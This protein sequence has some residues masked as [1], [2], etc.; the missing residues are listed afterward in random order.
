MAKYVLLDNVNH[1]DLK[2]ITDRSAKYG[3]SIPT[4]VTF[5]FEFRDILAHY[6]I[7][8]SKDP[9]SGQFHS[10]ALLGFAENE[11]LFL[12]EDGW[13]SSYVPLMIERQ[14]FSIGFQQQGQSV[15][16]EMQRVVHVDMDSPRTNMEEGQNLFLQHGGTTTYLQRI[17][18]VLEAVYQGQ[19]GSMKFIDALIKH[20]LLES[21]TLDVKL[22]DGSDNKLKG[23]YT[24]NEDKLNALPAETKVKLMDDGYLESIYMVLAS[25]SNFRALIERKN[26]KCSIPSH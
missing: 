11:N 25:F 23:F 18:S 26:Q 9:K 5:P 8:F 19:Q 1:K 20:Q 6:P 16:A 15:S 22:N 12:S 10:I 7:C 13:D 24:I 14:P 17:S 3:D 21:F 2:I 4:V